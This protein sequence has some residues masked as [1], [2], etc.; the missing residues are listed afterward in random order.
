LR[1][2]FSAVDPSISRSNPLR[3]WVPITIRLR[4]Q[5]D[6]HL[7]DLGRREPWTTRTSAVTDGPPGLRERAQVRFERLECRLVEQQGPGPAPNDAGGT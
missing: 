6:R 3:P 1:S 4:A 2:T 7:E 5:G